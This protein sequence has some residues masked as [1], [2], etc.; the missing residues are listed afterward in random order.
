MFVGF[1]Q[2]CQFASGG[3]HDDGQTTFN[4][5]AR[6]AQGFGGVARVG[7]CENQ[8][9][10]TDPAR[11]RSIRMRQHGMVPSWS[12]R[13]ERKDPPAAEPPMPRHRTPAQVRVRSSA[14][15]GQVRSLRHKSSLKVIHKAADVAEHVLAVKRMDTSSKR[16]RTLH[17]AS[18]VPSGP[19][20]PFVSRSR[21]W[22]LGARRAIRLD[23][24]QD[25]AEPLS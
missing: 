13:L 24:S 6:G 10:F 16:E 2:S 9:F 21:S 11:Q 5:R 12:A 7:R 3:H 15:H 17:H 19:H 4:G 18:A 1:C 8:P 25:Q 20:G 23:A 22:P 14:N